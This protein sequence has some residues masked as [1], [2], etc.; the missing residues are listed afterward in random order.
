MKRKYKHLFFDLD[1][2][3]FDFGA[4]QKIMLRQL[5]NDLLQNSAFPSYEDFLTIY[6]PINERLWSEYKDH[7][8]TKDDVKYGR[9][10]E[11]LLA[12]NIDDESLARFMGEQFVNGC[13]D[14][15]TLVE[16]A[17]ELIEEL[18]ENYELHIVSNGFVEAQYRKLEN[19]GLRPYFKGITLSEE[20]K[21]QKPHRR[22]FEHALKQVN[23]R[24]SE[25]LVIGDNW[26]CDVEGAINF[27]IDAVYFSYNGHQPRKNEVKTIFKLNE[28]LSV[29]E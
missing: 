26:E 17:K 9:F 18:F 27:G 25:S 13:T 21:T 10:R 5:Y 6:E 28:L 4:S 8:I 29:L 1:N 11:T 2:T 7:K 12:K 3:L 22:F 15:N 16:G 19:T 24:K 14:N 23:A 20:I